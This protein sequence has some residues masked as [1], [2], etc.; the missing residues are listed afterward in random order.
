MQCKRGTNKSG[1]VVVSVDGER[2][3]AHLF[4]LRQAVDVHVAAGERQDRLKDFFEQKR[5][6]SLKIVVSHENWRSRWKEE[7]LNNVDCHVRLRRVPEWL[8]G[9]PPCKH[10]TELLWHA[11][12]YSS[13]T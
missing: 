1:L 7:A 3:F 8:T 13:A 2:H 9:T 12:S 5:K 4:A 10:P 11:G 6:K